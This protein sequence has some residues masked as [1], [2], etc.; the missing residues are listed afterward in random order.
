M[1]KTIAF[2]L[3]DVLCTRTSNQGKIEKYHTCSPV[4]SMVEVVNNCYNDGNIIVIYTARG[5]TGFNGNVSEI[6]SNLYNLTLKQLN[7]WGIKFHKL[8]M[9]K[10]HYDLLIDDKAIN[11][12]GADN[13]TIN[14]F[15]KEQ[16]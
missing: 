1:K 11:S 4:K 16:V 5:M 9:G 10:L 2:D 3:D 8:V 6:Y 15:L 7:D 14:K 12:I 13:K